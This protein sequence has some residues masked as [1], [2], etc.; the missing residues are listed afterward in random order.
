[1]HA[2]V[3]LW[4]NASLERQGPCNVETVCC[5]MTGSRLCKRVYTHHAMS[6]AGPQ[7]T[8]RVS[9]LNALQAQWRFHVPLCLSLPHCTRLIHTGME[10]YQH[11]L[12]FF[13]FLPELQ[14]CLWNG[15]LRAMLSVFSFLMCLHYY[16]HG[17]ETSLTIVLRVLC[18]WR[19]TVW[20]ISGR[21]DIGFIGCIRWWWEVRK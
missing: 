9:F 10:E 12:S 6:A 7:H 17:L 14:A 3:F 8:H 21:L 20:Y 19:A 13:L 11:S 18:H 5:I 16:L 2:L 4:Q 1:M 15:N